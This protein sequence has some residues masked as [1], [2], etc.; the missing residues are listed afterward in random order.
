MCSGVAIQ[1]EEGGGGW[2]NI[3]VWVFLLG[4]NGVSGLRM[5]SS[6]CGLCFVSLVF[7]W[8]CFRANWLQL[9]FEL[10]TGGST[11]HVT[12]TKRLGSRQR[13][14]VLTVPCRCGA[15]LRPY[16]CL[17]NRKPRRQTRQVMTYIAVPH[18]VLLDRA[19]PL[20]ECFL[21]LL[22]DLFSVL[23]H[24]LAILMEGRS[25]ANSKAGTSQGMPRTKPGPSMRCRFPIQPERQHHLTHHHKLSIQQ[26]HQIRT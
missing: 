11:R 18:L 6:L 1:V 21:T 26:P 23:R 25:N 3:C 16:S 7:G 24:R 13:N 9:H 5:A 14:G 19:G 8:P 17:Q 12:R 10:A 22:Q 20:V 2:K 15:V 4:Q